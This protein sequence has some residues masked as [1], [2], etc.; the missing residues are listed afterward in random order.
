MFM[1]C[2]LSYWRNLECRELSSGTLYSNCGE[3][4]KP[5]KTQQNATNEA[6]SFKNTL[7]NNDGFNALF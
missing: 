3:V 5:G 1:S 2:K 4:G 6:C 7:K